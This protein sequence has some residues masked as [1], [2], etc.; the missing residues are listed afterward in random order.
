MSRDIRWKQR[1]ENYVFS[2][3]VRD[4]AGL[5]LPAFDALHS[6]LKGRGA[7]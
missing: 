2:Q 5:Y 4:M 7:S 6:F 1:F 3:A